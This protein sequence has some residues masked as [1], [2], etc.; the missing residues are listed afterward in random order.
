MDL[1]GADVFLPECQELDMS[2]ISTT[3]YEVVISAA[4][5]NDNSCATT[6]IHGVYCGPSGMAVASIVANA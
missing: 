4:S 1:Y 2:G 5:Q 3:D 6:G